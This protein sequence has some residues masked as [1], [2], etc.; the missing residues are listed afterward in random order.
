[1]NILS[2]KLAQ[3]EEE[4]FDDRGLKC[5]VEYKQASGVSD[6][7]YVLQPLQL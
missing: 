6:R 7:N 5:G 2:H 3:I 1:M 4:K